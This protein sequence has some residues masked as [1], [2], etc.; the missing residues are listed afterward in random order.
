MYIKPATMEVKGLMKKNS[1][2]SDFLQKAKELTAKRDEISNSYNNISSG[3][4]ERLSKMV[5][6]NL[7]QVGLANDINNLVSQ[8]RLKISGFKIESMGDSGQALSDPKTALPY[9]TNM[10]T[11]RVEGQYLDLLQ[12]LN[13]LE[14]NLRIMDV[15]SLDIEPG[16]DNVK[17]PGQM[18][19]SLQIK[20][21]TLK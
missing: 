20:T 18:Y 4:I 16:S 14:S 13:K 3:D 2:Y 7:D 12:F 1:E 17:F 5:P 21:Y 15:V 10:I 6:E 8:N 19:F 9:K 11:M